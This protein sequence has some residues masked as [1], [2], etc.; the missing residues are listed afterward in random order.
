MSIKKLLNLNKNMQKQKYF[1]HASPERNLKYIEPRTNTAPEGFEKGNVV[2]ATDSFQFS[3]MFLVSHDDSWANGGAF[4][5]TFFFVISD[6]ERF[7]RNDK[8][9]SVYLV[10]S[11]GFEK[12][13]K[14]EWFNPKSVKIKSKVDF[15]SGIEAMLITGVQVYFVDEETYLKIQ[16]SSDHGVSLLN[17]LKSENAR[18]GLPVQ[19]LELYTGSKKLIV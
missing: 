18:L 9:G 15:S 5:N 1:Y 2:F 19:W 6:K 8:G 3:T 4:G 17:S 12:F 13:N 16:N 14:H 10:D 7:E 11:K